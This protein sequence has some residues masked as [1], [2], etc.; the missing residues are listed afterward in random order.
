MGI[1][2]GKFG[3]NELLTREQLAAMMV[4]ILTMYKELGFKE[5]ER[6]DLARVI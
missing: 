1:T 3:P 4:K 5:I 6:Y 2:S